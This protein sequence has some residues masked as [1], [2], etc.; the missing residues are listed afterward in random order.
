MKGGYPASM[1]Y[2]PRG[3]DVWK[4]IILATDVIVDSRRALVSSRFGDTAQPNDVE[5]RFS[6]VVR[7][8]GVNKRWLLA[9]PMYQFLKDR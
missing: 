3:S 1:R 5:E 7:T 4:K 6:V 9:V 2:L 8:D